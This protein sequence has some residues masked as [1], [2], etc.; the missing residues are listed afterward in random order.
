MKVGAFALKMTKLW[1]GRADE[2]HYRGT[3]L[4]EGAFV[5]ADID[6]LGDG[7]FSHQI[8][9]YHPAEQI[10]INKTVL[11][12]HGGGYI[13]GTR[14]N[15]K[16]YASVFLDK[17]FD[18]VT[19][20]YP[21][22]NGKETCDCIVQMQVLAK[23]LRYIW[24]H[25]EELR[26]NRDAFFLT[27]D[28]AGGHFCLLLA[29]MVYDADLAEQFGVDL[30]GIRIRVVA[31]SCPVYDFE[32]TFY[33]PQL[34][35]SGKRFMFGKRYTQEGFAQLLSPKVHIKSLAIP[36]FLCSCKRDFLSQE[37]KDLAQDLKSI[38]VDQQ[39]IFVESDDPKVS[40]IFNVINI[41]HPES[42]RVNGALIDFFLAHAK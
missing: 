9:V 37:S 1:L 8:D 26:L 30:S 31:P 10:R 6:A 38:P 41:D 2:K 34:F 24:D 36:I 16:A 28:S 4:P 20:D 21:L 19:M 3:A 7:V 23:Q 18:V 5:D 11:D 27:G 29:E 35:K 32:R 33:T 17:G 25:A 13:Y 15:N 39:F 12:I 42:I 22:N 40:H 14:R